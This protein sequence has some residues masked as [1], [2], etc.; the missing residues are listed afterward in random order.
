[1]RCLQIVLVVAM[2][3]TISCYSTENSPIK[4]VAPEMLDGNRLILKDLNISIAAPGDGWKWME[5]K[6]GNSTAYACRKD[7]VSFGVLIQDAA[8][9]LDEKAMKNV[10][11]GNVNAAK[12]KGFQVS[13]EKVASA[14][15]PI[16]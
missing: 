2:L 7:K 14:D 9:N 8:W 6:N 4:P 10:L 11:S 3:T 5:V 16:E 1:M 13:D 12:A 15:T